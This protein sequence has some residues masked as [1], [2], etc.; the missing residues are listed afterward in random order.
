[1]RLLQVRLTVARAGLLAWLLL[2]TLVASVGVAIRMP[3][4]YSA[5]ADAV[6][7][8]P[9][10]VG[11]KSTNPYLQFSQALSVTLDVLIVASSDADTVRQIVASGGTKDYVVVRSHGVSDSEPIVTVTGKASSPEQAITTTTLVVKFLAADLQRRQDAVQISPDGRV[12]VVAITTPE[13]ASRQWKAPIEIGVGVLVLG[14][15]GSLLLFVMV[16]RYVV[17]RDAKRREARRIAQARP[18][19]PRVGWR[20]IRVAAT[21][22]A[23]RVHHEG[24]IEVTA[25]ASSDNGTRASAENELR[26]SA[27]NGAR[28]SA[29]NG[30]RGSAENGTPGSAE[31]RDRGEDTVEIARVTDEARTSQVPPT[32]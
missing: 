10:Q 6:L 3:A 29:E 22:A 13:Q 14:L 15:V 16:D 11:G 8:G 31:N 5:K 19:K 1:M 2:L 17:R 28:A 26:V 25:R 4:T 9:A 24:R 7:I 18:H 23:G 30:K 20:P 27:G 12:K 32:S 21:R